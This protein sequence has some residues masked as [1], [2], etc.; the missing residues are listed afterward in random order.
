MRETGT[1][2]DLHEFCSQKVRCSGDL[3]HRETRIKGLEHGAHRR[4]SG[5]VEEGVGGLHVGLGE[6]E[7]RAHRLVQHHVGAVGKVDEGGF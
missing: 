7:D 5:V 2:L 4:L 3:C 1:H 6:I